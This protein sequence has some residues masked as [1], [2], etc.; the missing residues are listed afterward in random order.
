MRLVTLFAL[1]SAARLAAQ[2]TEPYPHAASKKGLQVQMI[3][4]A[5]ALG[6]KHAALNCPVAPL[7][8][9]QPLPDSILWKCEGRDYAFRPSA[10]AALDQ[11]VKPL[12]DAGV[13]VSLI[14]LN[15]A[16]ADPAR[17]AILL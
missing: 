10:V 4:D 6:V 11:R 16:P 15:Y 8:D 1:L 9:P 2:R 12:S 7:I 17:A 13:I 5:L 14:V 3:D